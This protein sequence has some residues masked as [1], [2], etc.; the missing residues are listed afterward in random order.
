MCEIKRETPLIRVAQY[1]RIS[2]G[3]QKNSGDDQE[4][5]IQEYASN[6]GMEIVRTYID[7][8]KAGQNTGGKE[9]MK[10]M[11]S[12]V[13]SGNTDYKIILVHDVSRLGHFCDADQSAHY[14][15][16]CKQNGIRI[17]YCADQ[18]LQL[19]SSSSVIIKTIKRTMA[20]EFA[21]NISEKLLNGN[22]FFLESDQLQ[23]LKENLANVTAMTNLVAQ[24][25]WEESE[26]VGFNKNTH[27]AIRA[28]QES[29]EEIYQI[30]ND[31]LPQDNKKTDRNTT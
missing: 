12:D 14:E 23:I 19:E 1:V 11:F 7:G 27:T 13:T 18:Y 21:R 28:A 15:Y 22:G 8:G 16:T 3:H 10:Q 26:R 6:H 20:R 24:Y 4:Q 5:V 30:I 9:A 17:Q 2:A 31:N 25:S 29:L